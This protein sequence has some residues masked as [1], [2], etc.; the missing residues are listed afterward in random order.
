MHTEESSNNLGRQ[1]LLVE[2]L[3]SQSLGD[4]QTK[5]KYILTYKCVFPF[6]SET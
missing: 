5:T 3:Y 6:Q 1:L 4:A 2:S